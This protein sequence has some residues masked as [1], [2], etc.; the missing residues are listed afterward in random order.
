M[1]SVSVVIATLKPRDEIEAIQCL[2]QQAFDDFEVI[3]CDESPVTRARNEGIR[4]ASSDKIV[5]LDDDSRVRPGYLQKANEVLETEAAY[6]GRTIHPADDVFAR[7]FTGH[8]DWGDD[9]CYVRHF[10]GC[11]MGVHRDVFRTVGGWDEQMGWGHEEKELARRVSS[12]FDILYDPELIVDHPY[13]S[14]I[15]EYWRK[16]Y[17]LETKSPYYWSKCN[18][19]R[20]DQLKNISCEAFDPLN[21]IRITPTATVVEAG[22]TVAKTA[23][24]LRGFL[25]HPQQEADRGEVPEIDRPSQSAD[26]SE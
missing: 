10:W 24:R 5:F 14:S 3:V 7:H 22:S 15:T 17:K 9:A 19:S 25:S 16:Q 11:N 8:Y 23:G 13:A 1:V 20:A 4:R 12:K 21:Y 2:E 18:I 6:A 26:P